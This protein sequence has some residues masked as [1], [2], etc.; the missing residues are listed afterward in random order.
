MRRIPAVLRGLNHVS[1][2]TCEV[3]LR[4]TLRFPLLRSRAGQVCL[5]F[6]SR[7][8]RLVFRFPLFS[9]SVFQ[10]F[11]TACRLLSLYEP[12]GRII[13]LMVGLVITL[14]YLWRRDLV[15][16][17]IDHGLSD[18]LGLVLPRLFR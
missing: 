13:A 16:N 15:A 14:F 9:F 18:F 8:A 1:S 17:M 7:D 12:A 11:D 6:D 2:P 4:A 5:P 3:A 10:L